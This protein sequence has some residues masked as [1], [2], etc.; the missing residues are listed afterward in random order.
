[1]SS[2]KIADP[3]N[4]RYAV[5]RFFRKYGTLVAL[6]LTVLIFALFAPRFVSLLNFFNISRQIAVLFILGVAETYALIDG[7]IDLSIGQVAGIAGIMAAGA[8][9]AGAPT[10]VALA[11]SLVVGLIF[12]I[13]NGII[14]AKVRINSLITTIG[15]GQIAYGIN[16][17]FTKGAPIT[18]LSD[19]FIFVAAGKLF[20]IPFPLF[21]IIAVLLITDFHLRRTAS[22]RL[23]YAVGYNPEA[24]VMSGLK[25]ERIKVISFA[26]TGLLAGF[27]GFVIMARL[28]SGQPTAGPGYLGNAIAVG[29]LGASVLREGE[30]HTFG[31]LVG[32]IFVGVLVNGLTLFNVPY[33]YQ[34]IATGVV[35]LGAVMLAAAGKREQMI[36]NL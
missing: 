8:Q 12:G 9:S 13:A 18:G 35:L 25:A 21:I 14:I 11:V 23:L 7:E 36:T 10:M 17:L 34:F 32:A 29:F 19:S 15:I 33:F 20:G 27:G 24:S 5:L 4:K 28:G 26:I 30:F 6:G 16:F 3:E 2:K 31:T 1:M 22:G